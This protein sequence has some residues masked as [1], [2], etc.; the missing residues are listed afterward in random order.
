MR[1]FICLAFVTVF[2]AA[3][4]QDYKPSPEN[5]KARELFSNMRFGMFVHWGPYSVLGNGEWVMNNQNIKV[6]DYTTLQKLFNPVNFNA[7]Q[8]VANA[9]RAG[10]KY[11]TF[12]TRHHDGFSNW[13]TKQSDWKITNTPYGKDVFKQLTDECRKQGLKIVA[14]YSLLDW[15]RSDYQYETGETGRGTGRTAKSNWENYVAF[16]KAQ[17]TELL[18]NYGEISGIWFDGYWDQVDP[19]SGNHVSTHVDWHLNELYT[20]IHKLQPQCLIGNNHHIDPFPGEDFQLF[21]RDL[22]GQNTTGWSKAGISALPLET[23]E[24]MNQSWGF[25]LS[26][27]KFKSSKQLIHYLINAAGYNANFLLNVGPMSNGEIQPEFLDTLAVMGNWLSVHGETIYGTR[28]NIIPPQTWGT[29]TAKNKNLYAHITKSKIDQPFIFVP[30]AG[31]QVAKA[32]LF[33]N[34]KPLHFRQQ[35]E[36]VFVFLK[37]IKLND[38]DTVIKLHLK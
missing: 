15:Y 8:W 28:G 6:D 1:L 23:C 33:S 16:M 37:D 7:A 11:I 36:G 14:Y 34:N 29:L 20:L 17:L 10:M 31:V 5:Q 18:T 22:P 9:K 2:F 12:T 38:I 4:A 3:G 13:D 35:A 21:E 19:K 32:S 24:T 26:D 27:N 25:N 30:L